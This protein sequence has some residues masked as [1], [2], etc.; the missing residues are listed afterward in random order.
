MVTFDTVRA[1]ALT[2]PETEER[3]SYGTPAFRVR[4]KLFAR[5]REDGELLVVRIGFF[6]RDVLIA[7]NPAT[8][9]VTPHYQSSPM[10]L[11]RLAS[12]EPDEL[13]ELLT[14]AWRFAAPKRLVASYD[15]VPRRCS[16][17]QLLQ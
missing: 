10:V 13:Q 1:F 6:E 9:S 4:N 2:L 3:P 14:E 15:A 12:V 5:L 16:S 7:D 17:S 11:V 8:F